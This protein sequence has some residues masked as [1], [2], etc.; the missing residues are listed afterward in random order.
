MSFNGS[1]LWIAMESF[2]TGNCYI[3][4]D[5]IN[6]T[7]QVAASG[8]LYSSKIQWLSSAGLFIAGLKTDA[9]HWISTSP[10]GITWTPRVTPD[11]PAMGNFLDIACNDDMAV[12]VGE[13]SN[14][15]IYSADGITW[16][17]VVIATPSMCVTWSSDRSE[18]F[19]LNSF[20]GN[21]Y[22]SPDGITWTAQGIVAALGEI[23]LIW[24]GG[25]IQR[26]YITAQPTAAYGLAST[27]DSSVAFVTS[28]LDGA[29][30]EGMAYSQIAYLAPYNR[31]VLGIDSTTGIAYSTA[32][33]NDLKALSDNIRVRGSPVSIGSY[34]AYSTTAITNTAVETTL[35][36]ATS[37]GSLAFQAL[38]F[39][40]MS[41]RLR[42]VLAVT[43]TAGDTLTIRIKNQ[44]GTLQT[45]VFVIGALGTAQPLDIDAIITLRAASV[46][47]ISTRANVDAA[48]AKVQI[49]TGTWN[50][51]IANTISI[52]G[53]WG[54]A[55]SSVTTNTLDL[56]TNFRNSA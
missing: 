14:Q 9:T 40:G 13:G 17:L 41:I 49:N 2:G 10:D 55:L 37:L 8:S 39:V 16:T 35:V 24:V 52:T 20:F 19:A 48:V 33:P 34:S 15:L 7:Q 32:R 5:G 53:Q 44:A 26:Y 6:F 51:A 31:F 29:V 42:M 12:V 45:L 4:A 1:G 46:A 30:T 43:S 11:W 18:F 21:G 27:H 22:T 3:S 56:V 28:N 25:D 36:P 47:N 50:P 54:L 38:Q 23:C